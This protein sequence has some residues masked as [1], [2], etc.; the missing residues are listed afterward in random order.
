MWIS[1]PPVVTDDRGETC[2]ERSV[3]RS[4]A[5][6]HAIASQ[7]LPKCDGE[8]LRHIPRCM[9]SCATSRSWPFSAHSP[10]QCPAEDAVEHA[11]PVN[12]PTTLSDRPSRSAAQPHATETP[13]TM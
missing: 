5:G 9:M 4:S 8:Y 2:F 3:N 11:R 13:V 7:G 10:I 1:L 6:L 12:V